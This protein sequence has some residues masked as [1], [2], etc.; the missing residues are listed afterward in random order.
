MDREQIEELLCQALET[1][2]GGVEVYETA[3]RCAQN[4]KLK[5]E[6]E[7]YGQQTGRHVEILREIFQKFQIDPKKDSPGRQIVREKGQGLVLAMEKALADAPDAAQ[8]VAAE[9]VVDAETKD[10][11]NW[12]LLGS[13]RS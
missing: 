3:I 9:C 10:H 2:M 8:I 12:E 4:K 7:K 13:P 1:E 11:M 6:W 5:E